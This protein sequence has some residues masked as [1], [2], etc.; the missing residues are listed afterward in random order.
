[1]RKI[2]LT[3]YDY[4]G[5]TFHVAP[6]LVAILFSPPKLDAREVLRLDELARRIETTEDPT[7]L[8][9]EVDYARIVKGLNATDLQ[10]HGRSVVEFIRRVLDAPEVVVEEKR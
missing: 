4:E 7:V 1:M 8:L 3:N 2:D 5:Q 9:E 6:S 10:P